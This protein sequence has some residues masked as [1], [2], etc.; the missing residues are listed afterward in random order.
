[1]P[2]LKFASALLIMLL[3]S[4]GFSVYAQPQ[5]SGAQSGTLGPGTYIVVG[6]IRVLFGETLT[7]VPGTEF[8]HSGHFYWSIYGQ[9]NA[10]GAE[11]DSISFIRQFPNSTCRWGGI[12]F[13]PNSSSNSAL[14]YCI[15]DNVANGITPYNQYGGGIYVEDVPISITNSRISY[16]DAYWHGAGI[17][18]NAANVT[19]DN[20]VITDNT[21]TSGANGGGVYFYNCTEPSITNCIVARN[22]ATGT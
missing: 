10:E 3:L 7:I 5:I 22:S 11:E 14:D 20:C 17:Y 15:I 16:C 1:M 4:M 9:L 13:Q 19:I 21:A 2:K 8:L 6:D 18:A 12:R